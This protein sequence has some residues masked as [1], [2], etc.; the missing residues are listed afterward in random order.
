MNK[1]VFYMKDKYYSK[2]LGKYL[3][4]IESEFEIIF[5]ESIDSL[6][7]NTLCISDYNLG[8]EYWWIDFSKDRIKY[9]MIDNIIDLINNEINNQINRP[10]TPN[11]FSIILFINDHKKD[12]INRLVAIKNK[13]EKTL[14]VDFSNFSLKNRELEIGVDTLLLQKDNSYNKL[15]V[16]KFEGFDYLVATKLPIEMDNEENFSKVLDVLKNANYQN[17]YLVLDA[18]VNK[19]ILATINESYKLIIVDEDIS[20]VK[21]KAFLDTVKTYIRQDTQIVQ[22][23]KGKNEY[24]VSSDKNNLTLEKIDDLETYLWKY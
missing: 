16:N 17:I 22:V 20:K 19:R 15:S 10:F 2:I 7:T 4:N 1:L 11:L 23:S 18:Y 6:D 5:V 21:S 14:L 8:P 9:Q 24:K 3:Q 12:F 13:Y